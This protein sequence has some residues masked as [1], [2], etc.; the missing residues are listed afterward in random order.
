VGIVWDEM[1]GG[2]LQELHFRK[3][4][5]RKG[6]RN[7]C[8]IENIDILKN[9]DRRRRRKRRRRWFPGSDQSSCR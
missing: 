9:K 2:L 1:S 5:G 6:C 3:L 4:P 7:Q 8:K